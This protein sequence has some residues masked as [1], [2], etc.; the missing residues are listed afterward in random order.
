MFCIGPGG[1]WQDRPLASFGERG[2][3]GGYYPSLSEMEAAIAAFM[4]H[5]DNA[6][7]YEAQEDLTPAD[8]CFAPE[9]RL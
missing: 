8:L 2:C 6:G 9:E 5:Y 7:Y 1:Q 3:P 4:E